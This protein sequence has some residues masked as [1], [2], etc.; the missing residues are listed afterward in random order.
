M[1]VKVGG[2]LGLFL[3][4]LQ[5]FLLQLANVGNVQL[6]T[7]IL[8][9]FV[10][11]LED[12]TLDRVQGL[13]ASLQ[14]ELDLLTKRNQFLKFTLD[15]LTLLVLRGELFDGELEIHTS[16]LQSLAQPLELGL[17][18]LATCLR[19]QRLRQVDELGLTLLALALQ[20]GHALVIPARGLAILGATAA[21]DEAR[22]AD[23]H[24]TESDH[25]LTLPPT[26]SDAARLVQRL[27]DQRAT[28]G[29]ENGR[30]EALLKDQQIGGELG[31][32][33]KVAQLIGLHLVAHASQRD[34][35]GGADTLLPHVLYT[36][37]GHL[38]VLHHHRVGVSAQCHADGR[39]VATL[40]W[41]AH[42]G[43][44]AVHPA[45]ESLQ[46]AEALG[47]A[48]IA[49]RLTHVR[50]GLTQ[51]LLHRVQLLA[52]LDLLHAS[53]FGLHAQLLEGLL[54][55]LDLSHGGRNDVVHF[56]LTLSQL[57]TGSLKITKTTL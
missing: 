23:E 48:A 18:V 57:I 1:I 32:V 28:T 30:L 44:A 39:L 20:G 53:M 10:L 41:L 34:E 11:H 4:K 14:R 19:T 3:G 37:H 16:V 38:V 43:E 54:A 47:E 6:T 52:H 5:T 31:C 50:L 12:I 51:A 33:G 26:E 7:E 42:V 55:L 36:L 25:A 2:L 27:T 8:E 9:E 45:K 46:R 29:V 22:L 15:R 21:R 49:L 40:A 24:A 35:G 56:F 13:F 17:E